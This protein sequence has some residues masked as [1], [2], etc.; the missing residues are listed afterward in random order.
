L[1]WTA[2]PRSETPPPMMMTS[3][4]R[5]MFDEA[6]WG[7]NAEESEGEQQQICL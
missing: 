6:G 3:F 1:S 4:E 5:A 2:M 7:T